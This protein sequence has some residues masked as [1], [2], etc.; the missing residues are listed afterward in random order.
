MGL[1]EGGGGYWA[2][3]KWRRIGKNVDGVFVWGETFGVGEL[4]V[5][6]GLGI[7]LG[8]WRHLVEKPLES[9]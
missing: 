6:I 4:A 2:G 1:K 7:G 9:L 5:L 3:R 8:G